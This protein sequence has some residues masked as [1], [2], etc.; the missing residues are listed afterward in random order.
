MMQIIEKVEK[1]LEKLGLTLDDVANEH[2]IEA[3]TAK[4]ALVDNLCVEGIDFDELEKKLF[5]D[6][7]FVIQMIQ[8]L[9]EG[10]SGE[11]MIS[12]FL[13]GA[14]HHSPQLRDMLE[15]SLEE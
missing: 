12:A 14:I 4:I 15:I 2:I 7:T 10:G 8:H 9:D 3:C 11:D 6:S 13:V 5:P 1:E